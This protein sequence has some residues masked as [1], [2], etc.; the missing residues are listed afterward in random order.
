MSASDALELRHSRRI[1]IVLRRLHITKLLLGRVTL[2]GVQHLHDIANASHAEPTVQHR[3]RRLLVH[4]AAEPRQY[5]RRLELERLNL[6]R[7]RTLCFDCAFLFHGDRRMGPE[8]LPKRN[9][10]QG[11]ALI[12]A[13]DST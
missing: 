13:L 4:I 2:S 7:F 1:W 12:F 10:E 11:A 8:L 6:R 9:L 5:P 3:E